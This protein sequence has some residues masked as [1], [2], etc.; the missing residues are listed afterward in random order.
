MAELADQISRSRRIVKSVAQR[1][2]LAIQPK[3]RG[4]NLTILRIRVLNKTPEGTISASGVFSLV[5]CSNSR[6]LFD[7]DF[8]F[9]FGEGRFCDRD[10]LLGESQSLLT[11]IYDHSVA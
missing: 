11:D 6:F 10:P 7:Q 4:R 5:C 9:F 8:L 3:Q 2:D 1:L